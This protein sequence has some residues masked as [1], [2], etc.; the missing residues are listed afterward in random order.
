MAKYSNLVKEILDGI[1]GKTNIAEVTHCM[2]RLRFVLKDEQKANDEKIK[3]IDGILQLVKAQ[4]QYMI[5]I[6]SH[7]DKVYD[8]LCE[9]TGVC[10]SAEAAETKSDEKTLTRF[11]RFISGI[12]FPATYVMCACAIINGINILLKYV[13]ILT[14][15]DGIYILLNGMGN[16]VLY[17]LPVFY[18][19][20]TAKQVKIDPFIGIGIGAALCNPNI[21]GIPLDIFGF[22]I[23]ATYTSTV[24]PVILIVLLASPI[25]KFLNRKVP[26]ILR[27]FGVPFLTFIIVIPLGFCL[28]GPVVNAFGTLVGDALNGL[29]AINKVLAGFLIAGLWNVSVVLGIRGVISLPSIANVIGGIPDYFGAMRSGVCFAMAATALAVF[30]KTKNMKMK[31]VSLPAFVSAMFGVT[32]PALY[33]VAVPNLKV[34]IG[35]LVSSGLGG[36][37]AGLFGAMAYSV[38]SGGVFQVVGYI[39]PADPSGST[40]AIMANYIVS[41]VSAFIITWFLFKDQ[42]KSSTS[43]QQLENVKKH[44]KDKDILVESPMEGEI[45]TLHDVDDPAFASGALGKGIAVI[46]SRGRVIAPFD[47]TVSALFNTHHAIGLTSVDGVEMLIHIGLETVK[48][49]GKYFTPHVKQGDT[50]KKGDLLIEFDIAKIKEEGYSLETPIV[51]SNTDAFDDVMTEKS[52]NIHMYENLFVVMNGSRG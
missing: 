1:G 36:A 9:Q 41:F 27:G 13:G 8:E 49:E 24:L 14:P 22:E 37:V 47:G 7:V 19:Y 34:F 50:V 23:T 40:I 31:N 33:G 10:A 38:G 45:I 18:G 44:T 3:Q 16:A 46:P 39:N 21:S 30:I 6:G 51:I 43:L 20:T 26:D 42:E 48:L 32:E 11:M 5:V 2:T 17:L 15:E 29:I 25:A 28:I 4:G 12:I 52:T 35:T